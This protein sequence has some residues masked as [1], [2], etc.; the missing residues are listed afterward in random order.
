MELHVSLSNP[1]ELYHLFRYQLSFFQNFQHHK[2]CTDLF[3][4]EKV[5]EQKRDGERHTSF[6][7][8][9]VISSISVF[10]LLVQHRPLARYEYD[11]ADIFNG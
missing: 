6:H 3:K 11:N 1:R 4:R 10:S 9:Q 2:K 5:K 8:F 7:S